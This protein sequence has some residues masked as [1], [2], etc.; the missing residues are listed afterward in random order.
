MI[1]ETADEQF[2]RLG[3]QETRRREAERLAL[4]A[5]PLWG[6]PE[7]KPV[8]DTGPPDPDAPAP[9]D[10]PIEEW[11]RHENERKDKQERAQGGRGNFYRGPQKGKKSYNY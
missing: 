11:M 3:M 2:V 4:L 5:T 8:V 10:L 1:Y 9:D 7:V 6:T